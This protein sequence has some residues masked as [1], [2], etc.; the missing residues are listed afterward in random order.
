MT[1]QSGQSI[2]STFQFVWNHAS[3]SSP[4]NFGWSTIMKWSSLGVDITALSQ[5]GQIFQLV[6]VKAS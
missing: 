5:K 1:T 2:V 3:D 6:S 4:E